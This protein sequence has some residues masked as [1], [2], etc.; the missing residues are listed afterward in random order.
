MIENPR[1]TKI[2]E[3]GSSALWI[4]SESLS[5]ARFHSVKSTSR[6]HYLDTVGKPSFLGNDIV[7]LSG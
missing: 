6:R 1:H 4:Y 2:I 7:S 3:N 5:R